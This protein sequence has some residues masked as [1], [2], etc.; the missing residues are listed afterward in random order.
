MALLDKLVLFAKN[1]NPIH[2]LCSRKEVFKVPRTGLIGIPV[3]N[4]C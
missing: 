4:N 3:N 2:F 1:S